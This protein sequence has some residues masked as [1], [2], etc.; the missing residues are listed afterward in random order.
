MRNYPPLSICRPSWPHARRILRTGA[1]SGGRGMS[2]KREERYGADN[3]DFEDERDRELW[4]E[5]WEE[6]LKS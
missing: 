4:Q 5:E 6:Y 2:G 3:R 1:I